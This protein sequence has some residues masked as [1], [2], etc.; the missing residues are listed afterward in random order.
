MWIYRLY[1]LD[2][3]LSSTQP[4]GET[5]RGQAKDA[6]ARQEDRQCLDIKE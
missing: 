5:D 4:D 3:G 1:R 2:Y 6:E